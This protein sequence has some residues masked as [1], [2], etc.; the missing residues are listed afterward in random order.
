MQ[1]AA[2][3]CRLAGFAERAETLPDLYEWDYGDYEGKFGADIR[4]ARPGWNLFHDGAAGGESPA[5]VAARA[6]RVLARYRQ[7]DADVLIFS[8]GHL[9]RVLAARFLGLGAEAGRL[10]RLDTASISCLGYDH[11]RTEPAIRFWNV[12]EA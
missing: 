4:A 8:S 3:T 10:F 5:D 11:D 1:R 6:D 9:L 2:E 12:T 7:S